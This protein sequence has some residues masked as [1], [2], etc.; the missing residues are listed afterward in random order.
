[1]RTGPTDHRWPI[2]VGS[3]IDRTSDAGGNLLSCALEPSSLHTDEM[4]L[5][6]HLSSGL[7]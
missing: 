7:R 6:A 5:G 2:P 3:P 1:M 4:K